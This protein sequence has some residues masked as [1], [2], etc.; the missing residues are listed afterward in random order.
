MAFAG[1]VAAEHIRQ[2]LV[3]FCGDKTASLSPNMSGDAVAPP[4]RT[5][6]AEWQVGVGLRWP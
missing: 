1:A 3:A 5:T 2:R 6:E 4:D